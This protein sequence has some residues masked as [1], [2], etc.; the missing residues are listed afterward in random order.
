M[1]KIFGS[2][3]RMLR[4]YIVQC[5]SSPT[6]TFEVNIKF[7]LAFVHLQNKNLKHVEHDLNLDSDKR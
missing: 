4:R 3:K 1:K 7:D 2:D 5:L 6:Y